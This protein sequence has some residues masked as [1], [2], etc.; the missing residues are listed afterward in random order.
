MDWRFLQKKAQAEA[1]DAPTAP[2][3]P[4]RLRQ[5]AVAGALV[6]LGAVGLGGWFFLNQDSGPVR[7]RGAQPNL[8]STAL[9]TVRDVGVFLRESVTRDLGNIA[10]ML[11][12]SDEDL[13][14]AEEEGEPEVEEAPI[15]ARPRVRRSSREPTAPPPLELGI[16]PM[17]G[18][19]LA[20][21]SPLFIVFD[22]SHPDVSPPRVGDIRLRSEFLPESLRMRET[23][24]LGPNSA[25]GHENLS[26]EQVG[27]VEVI[28]SEMGVVEQAKLIS[29]PQNVHESMLLSAIK[30]WRFIPAEKD[31]MA[32][33]Y[34][35]VMPITVAR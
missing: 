26:S 24:E 32:V 21:E 18:A 16:G 10:T 19:E 33:R 13:E 25:A 8:A 9:T 12:R 4:S 2:K 17:A 27:L 15:A 14:D 30:A 28:V 34:R 22:S 1:N 20:L 31:G 11:R 35:Q 29:V 3:G 5:L 23:D 7:A 6:V